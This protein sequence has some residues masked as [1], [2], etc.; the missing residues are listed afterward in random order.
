MIGEF[1]QAYPG[2]VRWRVAGFEGAARLRMRPRQLASEGLGNDASNAVREILD[3]RGWLSAVDVVMSRCKA[4]VLRR[5][6]L[7]RPRSQ[8]RSH[9]PVN[10]SS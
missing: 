3:L 7:G 5:N 2:T 8:S 1:M 4:Q 6:A 9:L 10:W